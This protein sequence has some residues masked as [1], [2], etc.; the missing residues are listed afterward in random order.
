MDK[1]E[2]AVD[3]RP[4]V[5]LPAHAHFVGLHVL[6]PRQPNRERIALLRHR[7]ELMAAGEVDDLAV[8]G[9]DFFHGASGTRKR[10]ARQALL[11]LWPPT[12]TTALWTIALRSAEGPAFCFPSL[13][14]VGPREISAATSTQ[15][16]SRAGS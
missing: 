8:V 9:G 5:D 2:V 13:P 3:E 11:A 1:N 6:A 12:D 15:N 7:E 4:K 10:Q 14:L 16:A